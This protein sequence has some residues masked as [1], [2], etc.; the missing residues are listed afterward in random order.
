MTD[1]PK[2]YL[3]FLE[4][5]IRHSGLTKHEFLN[6]AKVH[7]VQYNAMLRRGTC[8]LRTAMRILN[9][10]GYV[11]VIKYEIADDENYQFVEEPIEK[12]FDRDWTSYRYLSGLKALFWGNGELTRRACD[13]NSRDVRTFRNIIAKDNCDIALIY[14]LARSA[15]FKARFVLKKDPQAAQILLSRSE[16]ETD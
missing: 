7:P 13:E 16:G 3:A 12:L 8:L 14:G 6:N 15:G 9:A 10:N 11:C 2:N 1:E 4:S 5:A